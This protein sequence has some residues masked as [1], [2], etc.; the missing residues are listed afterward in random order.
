MVCKV[1]G[2][3]EVRANLSA[4]QPQ[5]RQRQGEISIQLTDS[6]C[7]SLKYTTLHRALSKGAMSSKELYRKL[8]HVYEALFTSAAINSSS[9][10]AIILFGARFLSSLRV[11]LHSVLVSAELDH[12]GRRVNKNRRK[13]KRTATVPAR[14]SARTPA[15]PS[16]TRHI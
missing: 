1:S 10:A 6:K 15:P 12:R 16:P 3:E 9:C 11:D 5:H 4:P 8:Y 14:L 13:G 7:R 2:S